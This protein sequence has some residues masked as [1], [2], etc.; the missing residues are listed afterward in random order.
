MLIDNLMIFVLQ[1]MNSFMII[2]FWKADSFCPVLTHDGQYLSLHPMGMASVLAN[3][4]VIVRR[5]SAEYSAKKPR[6]IIYFIH[7]CNSH[8][9]PIIVWK[10]ERLFPKELSLQFT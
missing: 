7:I 6:P 5:G 1:R 9:V 2:M 8:V 3:D 10:R 4:S